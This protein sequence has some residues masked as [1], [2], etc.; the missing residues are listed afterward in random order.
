[1]PTRKARRVSVGAWLDV[2]VS[3]AA[4][5]AVIASNKQRPASRPPTGRAKPIVLK[6]GAPIAG[7]AASPA[8]ASPAELSIASLFPYHDRA[9]LCAYHDR[10]I[11]QHCGQLSVRNR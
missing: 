7:F 6:Y 1:M 4:W 8:L 5:L 11:P 2:R 9:P 3:V 10:P